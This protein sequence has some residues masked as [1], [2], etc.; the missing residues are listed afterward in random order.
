MRKNR[1]IL[2]K[3]IVL[4]GII[5]FLTTGIM[6]GFWILTLQM[7]DFQSFE[8]RKII[9]STK[10]YDRTGK[11]LLYD[12]HNNIKRTVI[13]FEE[14]PR[15]IKNATIAIEDID[16]Y[17]HHGIKPSA[18]L[19]A[20]L[21]NMFSGYAK[22]GG[23]TITQQLI[24]NTFLTSEKTI[25]R[26]IKEIILAYKVEEFY[27]KDQILGFYFN[28]IPYGS[29][30]YGIEAAAQSFFG[31]RAKDL[32]LGEAAYLAALPK[33]PTY[34][35]PYGSHK[36]KL[37]ERKNTILKK[38]KELGFV[39][40]KEYFQAKNEKVKFV[41]RADKNIK[42]PHFVMFIR[43]YLIN[44]FG[45]GAIEQDGLIVT[46]TLDWNLQNKAEKMILEYSKKIE[47]KFNAKNASL[48]AIDP[49]TGQIL[50]MVGSRDYF[51]TENDGNFNVATAKR[52]PG[53]AFK[54]FV[55]AAA[56]EKG[57][58]PET[59]VF[60]LE[61]EFNTSCNPD[62]TPILSTTKPEECYMPQNYDNIF[63]GPTTLREALAQSINIPS[64]KVLY[65]AGLKNSLQTAKKL[66]ITTL[67]DTNRYGLTLV[68]GG[69]EVKLL[70]MVA[71]Y[72]VFANNGFKNNT[73][74]IIEIKN[75]KG[76]ILEK[77]KPQPKKVLEEN[78]ALIINDILSDN[79]ART[80][81]FGSQ[82]YL[83][84][85]ERDVAVK[86]GTTNDYRDAWVIGYTPN[87]SL[88]LWVGNN[89]N[90]PMKKKIAGFIAA[91]LWNSFFKEVFKNLPKESFKKPVKIEVE[92]PVLKGEWKGSEVYFIDS[93]SG[94]LATEF[95][96][97]NLVKE[98]VVMN[99]HSI[100]HWV[101]KNNPLGKIPERPEK[102]SQYNLWEYPVQNWVKYQNIKQETLNDIP[103]EY[104]D[105]HKPEYKPIIKIM[106]PNQNNVFN[107]NDIISLNISILSKFPL[108]QIDFFFKEKYL[109]SIK[110]KNKKIEQN[111]KFSFDLS[112]FLDL[113]KKE[114]VKIKVYDKVYNSSETS[115]FLNINI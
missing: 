25:T 31:K 28:E 55:Y 68:L 74:G 61:T 65:L 21:I 33:A 71:A 93:V 23:S 110:P 14:I 50:V 56:F 43:N 9:Q 2:L 15:N 5:S 90:T 59:V 8:Q 63:R 77:I 100:L 11:I 12:I 24:K 95:T 17:Q 35:S 20:F 103:K 101:D 112:S 106:Q 70:E 104:D 82:S 94:K 67:K 54:P 45:E 64:V 53:S 42:A 115:M 26:K 109:G 111:I 7:P 99:I 10:I 36:D 79:K 105:I 98:K 107:R 91:P 96:P 46:T 51:D 32:T 41:S 34:Y 27:N 16:F 29:N 4:I 108:K 60:D 22:Q 62:G 69:G 72:S 66:G 52:Q 38:M 13:P 6:V 86:T 87:F 80:P 84:F 76:E 89:D 18:I 78:I 47:K 1:F 3:I 40:E 97:K 81:A 49:K 57:Y 113:N 19:R 102:D 88:G 85:P 39:S 44:K 73:T 58:T 48:V 37:E 114:R 75:N 83:Y 92:K 30:N